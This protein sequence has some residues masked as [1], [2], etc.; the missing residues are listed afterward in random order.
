MDGRARP[1]KERVIIGP[2]IGR[3]AASA[4]HAQP[5]PLTLGISRVH[6]EE[7]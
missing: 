6:R 5:V 4:G 2:V 7:E 1:L 3:A